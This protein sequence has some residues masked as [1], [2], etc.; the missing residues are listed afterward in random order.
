MKSTSKK[1]VYGTEE[2]GQVEKELRA[3]ALEKQMM[4]EREGTRLR[5][6]RQE[7]RTK[8]FK[9]AKKV[10]RTGEK[11]LK[12]IRVKLPKGKVGGKFAEA[13]GRT[14]QTSGK[15]RSVGR[16]RGSYKRGVPARQFQKFQRMMKKRANIQAE[17]IKM[18]RI[19][20]LSKRGVPP[21]E[22]R[23][24]VETKI[25]PRI[26]QRL[27]QTPIRRP[28]QVPVQRVVPSRPSERWLM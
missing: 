4:K 18:R 26:I 10:R 17:Q 21:E 27:R 15:K 13:I 7:R 23:M 1:M 24:I 3:A 9:G 28:A 20:M 25:R 16:P 14:V 8:Y 22:A 19:M 11:V 12:R 5:K 2:M 6:F